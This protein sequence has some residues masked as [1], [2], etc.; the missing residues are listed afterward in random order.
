M[1]VTTAYRNVI[2]VNFDSY[3]KTKSINILLKSNK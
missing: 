1:Y 2:A 3:V